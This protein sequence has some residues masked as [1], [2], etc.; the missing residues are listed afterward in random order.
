[1][2]ST[3]PTGML[4]CYLFGKLAQIR[5]A[6]P[7]TAPSPNDTAS[8]LTIALVAIIAMA[9]QL[10]NE[11]CCIKHERNSIVNSVDN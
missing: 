11:L 1:M 9:P 6:A 3:H 2:G 4:S 8:H 7:S 5:L 10:V